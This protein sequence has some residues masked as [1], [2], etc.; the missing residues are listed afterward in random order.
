MES[1]PDGVYIAVDD[2]P[3]IKFDEPG[4]GLDWTSRRLARMLAHY[5]VPVSIAGKPAATSPFADEAQIRVE[6]WDGDLMRPH[7]LSR[8]HKVRGDYSS[9]M[10]LIDHVLYGLNNIHRVTRDG[11]AM[12]WKPDLDICSGVI[13]EVPDWQ[14]GQ[15]HYARRMR[16][17]AYPVYRLDT[18]T[19][20]FSELSGFEFQQLRHFASLFLCR[21]PAATLLAIASDWR[22]RQ[23]PGAAA[24]IRDHSGWSDIG[25][26]RPATDPF[27]PGKRNERLV[28][29]SR[30]PLLTQNGIPVVIDPNL[31]GAVRHSVALAL[32][33][34]STPRLTPVAPAQPPDADV[35]QVSVAE[36]R[37]VKADRETVV[38]NADDCIYPDEDRLELA[39]GCHSIV[40]R[41]NVVDAGGVKSGAEVNMSLF[42]S[43]AM[44]EENVWLAGDWTPAR[45][46]ELRDTLFDAFWPSWD[47]PENYSEEDYNRHLKTLAT[48]MLC[49]P[50]QGFI[51]ELE[52][53]CQR[54]SPINPPPDRAMVAVSNRFQ[55]L[56]WLPAADETAATPA[57]LVAA[58][59]GANPTLDAG[60]ARRLAQLIHSDPAR[61]TGLHNS[62]TAF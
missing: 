43:G 2:W 37:I 49:G 10:A 31:D 45:T 4:Q 9:A 5:P 52:Q 17:M 13:Y 56:L 38:L 33:R 46:D 26:G 12:E 15:S 8:F 51:A 22:A 32:Y 16:Y 19:P 60:Q 50:E 14:D 58:V 24:A 48:T 6:R 62:L 30:V 54:F 39:T 53:A 42:C 21:P 23:E 34:N 7:T 29:S 57:W 36:V 1:D 3:R 47:Q 44:E 11:V 18:T 40:A 59:A 20:D 35:G 61:L 28:E 25:P 27:P 41:L 55:T